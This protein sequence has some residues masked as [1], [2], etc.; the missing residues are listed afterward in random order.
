L[1]TIYNIKY[2]SYGELI[3]EGYIIMMI[4]I[5]SNIK[6]AKHILNIIFSYLDSLIFFLLKNKAIDKHDIDK[7]GHILIYQLNFIM[8]Y[9]KIK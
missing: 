2:E 8:I 6:S 1:L 4:F 9:L 3:L 7:I 5:I